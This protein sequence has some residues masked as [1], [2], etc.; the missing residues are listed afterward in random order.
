MPDKILTNLLNILEIKSP[1]SLHLKDFHIR[2]GLIHAF[3][4]FYFYY[5][6]L[7]KSNALQFVS[8]P[9]PLSPCLKT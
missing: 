1:N 8:P 2:G 6:N 9:N 7:F 5:I 3:F 4:R